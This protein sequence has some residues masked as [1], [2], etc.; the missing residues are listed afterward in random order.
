MEFW[1]APL[2]VQAIEYT[3][4]NQQMNGEDW[5]MLTQQHLR[6]FM[7]ALEF[8]MQGLQH[9][10]RNKAT[11]KGWWPN[12]C[13]YAVGAPG[14]QHAK[15]DVALH[16]DP[17]GDETK[18][19]LMVVHCYSNYGYKPPEGKA[20]LALYRG[21]DL[22]ERERLKLEWQVHVARLSMKHSQETHLLYVLNVAALGSK[23]RVE[24]AVLDDIQRSM[25]KAIRV[26]MMRESLEQAKAGAA[27]AQKK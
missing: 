14:Q 18:T 4:E 11:K 21:M 16:V 15:L 17:Q 19:K 23:G 7:F 24:Q 5:A 3:R 20:I 2:P 27:G 22:G 10:L 12:Q 6:E 13:P 26:K 1:P 9:P 8:R 25:K